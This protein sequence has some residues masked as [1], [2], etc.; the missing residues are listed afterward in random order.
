MKAE[1]EN[2][3]LVK[4]PRFKRYYVVIML[5]PQNPNFLYAENNRK[6]NRIRV[7]MTY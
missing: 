4:Q 2:T 1:A 6:K 5:F 3:D 7:S